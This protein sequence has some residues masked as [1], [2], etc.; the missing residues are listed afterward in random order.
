MYGDRIVSF[1]KDEPI[2]GGY[3]NC[4]YLLIIGFLIDT[5]K[6][7]KMFSSRLQFFVVLLLMFYL[8]C[9]ILTGERSNTIRAFLGLFI[10]ISIFILSNLKIEKFF[11]DKYVLIFLILKIL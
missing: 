9:I 10:F 5:F 2:V 3:L 4:F 1:F 6:N 8:I 7:N 11:F